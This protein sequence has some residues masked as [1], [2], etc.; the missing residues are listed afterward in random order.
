MREFGVLKPHF[1][2]PLDIARVNNTLLVQR[3]ENIH[4]SS[5]VVG[6]VSHKDTWTPL[7][8]K[9]ALYCLSRLDDSYFAKSAKELGPFW[10]ITKN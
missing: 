2:H 5:M 7:V 4:V 3:K 10:C 9:L 1:I 6:R 8:F